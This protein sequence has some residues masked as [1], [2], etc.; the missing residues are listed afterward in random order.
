MNYNN[1]RA[2]TKSSQIQL[3]LLFTLKIQYAEYLGIFEAYLNKV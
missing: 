3:V 1:F 2:K